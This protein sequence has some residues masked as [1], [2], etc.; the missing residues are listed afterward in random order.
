MHQ[1][2]LGKMLPMLDLGWPIN[3]SDSVDKVGYE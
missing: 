1:F 3:Y 2:S